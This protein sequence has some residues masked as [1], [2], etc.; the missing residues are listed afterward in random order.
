VWYIVRLG[1]RGEPATAIGLVGYK[2]PPNADGVV[3][4]G[5]G[6]L[7]QFRR[8]GYAT[9]AVAALIQRAFADPRVTRVAAETYPE[10]IPSIGVMEI[11]GMRFVGPGSEDRVIRDAIVREAYQ[12]R[13][14]RP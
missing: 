6:V 7:E 8:R 11:N 14:G 9:E 12:Q 2:G 13:G 10:L 4:V 5:Y 3:E 1:G